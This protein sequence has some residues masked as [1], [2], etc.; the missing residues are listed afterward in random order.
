MSRAAARKHRRQSFPGGAADCV[1]FR[2]S[3][4]IG[5]AL[6]PNTP[7]GASSAVAGPNAT[8]PAVPGRILAGAI[9][10]GRWARNQRSSGA[11]RHPVC[12]STWSRC[13]ASRRAD[14]SRGDR[15]GLLSLPA[16]RCEVELPLIAGVDLVEHRRVRMGSAGSRRGAAAG[17]GS[18]SRHVGSCRIRAQAGRGRA[19]FAP[20]RRGCASR[21]PRSAA[22]PRRRR[23]C[24]RRRGGASPGT[25]LPSTWR[26]SLPSGRAGRGAGS[27]RP[28]HTRRYG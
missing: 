20:L 27:C 14:R 2:A 19:I 9:R 17:D 6:R 12:Q 7:Y 10:R 13:G 23:S 15:C 18:K 21:S 1:W 28:R 26:S 16:R 25:G 8:G 22:R 5:K 3:N 4:C 24:G 11:P